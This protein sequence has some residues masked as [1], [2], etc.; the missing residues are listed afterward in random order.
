[1]SYVR[2]ALMSA[3]L[4][5]ALPTLA[6]AQVAP[7]SQVVITTQL[8]S[9][10]VVPTTAS[11]VTISA[12]GPSLS[13]VPSAS[14]T[15]QYI[16]NFANESRS[17]VFVPGSYSVTAVSAPGYYYSYSSGCTGFTTSSTPVQ[18]CTITLSTTPPIAPYSCGTW[19]NSYSC[20]Q[21]PAPYVGPI[22][23][24][25][26]ACYPAYQTVS[27]GQA[28]TFTTNGTSALG[29]N[30]STAGRAFLSI[31]PSLTTTFQGTGVQTVIVSQGTQL[32]TCTVNVVATTLPI[33][34]SN[35][36]P[37]FIST[38]IPRL[39]NT[40]FAPQDATSFAVAFVLL[41]ALGI[42]LYPYVRSTLSILLRA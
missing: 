5:I 30:W 25:T 1:M 33:V 23:G 4:S 36:A 37:T 28:A 9:G 3:A 38:Y 14:P 16:T 39:P 12:T 21:P 11:T 15:L 32:A 31:G 18:Y 2:I 27:A 35:A 40:G 24:P 34:Y 41:L 22:G 20:S 26:L 8:G 29:Y 19:P 10:V 6:M 17:V 7:Y 13:G 42:L